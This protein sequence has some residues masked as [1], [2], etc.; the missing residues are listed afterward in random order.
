[1]DTDMVAVFIPI[2]AIMFGVAC[3]IVSIVVTHRQRMQRAE[4]RHRERLAAIEKGLELPP[5]PPDSDASG[6]RRRP[7]F[8]LRGLVLL[9]VGI[10]LTVAMQQLPGNAPYLFGTIPGAI[11]LGYLIYYFIEGRREP[12][13]GAPAAPANGTPTQ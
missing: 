3:A 5:D 12:G 9:F 4:L 1:M 6:G 10:A 11:G 13:P 2:T 8:L 7:R